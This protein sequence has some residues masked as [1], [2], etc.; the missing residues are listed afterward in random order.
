MEMER[1]TERLLTKID[2]RKD[3]STKIMQEIMD[4]N[5]KTM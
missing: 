1:M 5:T 3:A 2:H 4:A